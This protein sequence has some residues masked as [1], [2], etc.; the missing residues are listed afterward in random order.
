M[1]LS[2]S[3]RQVLILDCC[4]SG[5]FVERMEAKQAIPIID[6]K[7]QAQL[8]GEGRV[9][10]TSSTVLRRSRRRILYPLS[11]RGN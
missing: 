4:F 10:L 8:G 9:V 11:N 6:D 7:I 1:N 3:K 2:P 5:A